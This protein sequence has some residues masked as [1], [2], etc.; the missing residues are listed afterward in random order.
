MILNS[1]R[2]ASPINTSEWKTNIVVF[3][4]ESDLRSN[5]H[6][7]SS[8]ENETWKKIQD[9]TGFEPMTSAIPVQRSTNWAN[10]PISLCWFQINPWTDEV[11]WSVHP[12]LALTC[13]CNDWITKSKVTI[14]GRILLTSGT[15]R[16]PAFLFLK[17]F[18]PLFVLP[19]N[20]LLKLPRENWS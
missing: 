15:R 8:S 18:S 16:Q 5:K 17:N 13:V 2:H 19:H 20:V 10:K 14:R 1:N 11:K 7:L 4:Y 6:Y 3:E 9:C 12:L